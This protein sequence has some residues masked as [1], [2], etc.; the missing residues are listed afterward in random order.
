AATAAAPTPAFL[1]KSRLFI[2][3][4]SFHGLW[5]N[6]HSYRQKCNSLSMLQKVLRAALSPLRS[7]YSFLVLFTYIVE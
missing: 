1:R 5:V 3:Q 2:L 7:G 6:F 4:G